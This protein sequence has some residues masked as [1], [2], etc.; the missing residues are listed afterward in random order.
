MKRIRCDDKENPPCHCYQHYAQAEGVQFHVQV[1]VPRTITVRWADHNNVVN[2]AT[3]SD[4]CAPLPFTIE[5]RYR[6]ISLITLQTVN[7]DVLPC[8]WLFI[9][10]EELP[11]LNVSSLANQKKYDFPVLLQPPSDT[12]PAAG[13]VRYFQS[14]S[15]NAPSVQLDEDWPG[16]N[17]L[18]L[19]IYSEKGSMA[20]V[21]SDGTTPV[22]YVIVFK[23][24]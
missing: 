5:G 17:K 20:P 3:V 10:A 9:A 7:A 13:D 14:D 22:E 6:K 2:P 19:H 24:E 1:P 12:A 18:T 23:V 8:K 21:T 11:G 16:F 4:W 15:E